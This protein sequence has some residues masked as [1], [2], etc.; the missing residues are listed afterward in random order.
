MSQ[1]IRRES[2]GYCGSTNNVC[3]YL[4]SFGK[5][6]SKCMTPNCAYNAS[7]KVDTVTESTLSNLLTIGEYTD[8]P[9]RGISERVCIEFNYK[10]TVIKGQTWHI[11]HHYDLTGD[12]KAQKIRILPKKF[13]WRGESHNLRLGRGKESIVKDRAY[14]FES[15]LDAMSAA[16]VIQDEAFTFFYLTGGAGKQTVYEITRNMNELLKYN[17]IVVCFDNDLAGN[18]EIKNVSKLF[19]IGK[20]KVIKLKYKDPN[21]YLQKQDSISLIDDL[22]NI[23]PYIPVEIVSPTFEKVFSERPMGRPFPEKMLNNY[24]RGLKAGRLY[25]LLAGP[26][27]GK[28][29]LTRHW[30]L[31]WLKEDDSLKIAVA[32]LEEPV[33]DSALALIAM[34]NNKPYFE[35][36][37]KINE[38]KQN[39]KLIQTYKKYIESGRIKFLDASFMKLDG[40]DLLYNLEYFAELGYSIIILDH[41]S[42]IT[43]DTLGN[44]SERKDI[45]ILMKRLR[46]LAHKTQ[47]SIIVVC[48]LK[49][50]SKGM[51]WDQ[52]REISMSDGRG[53]GVYEQVCDVM[54]AI[55]R[56]QYDDSQK[57]QTK[58]KVLA[59][60]ITGLTGYADVLYYMED[61]GRLCTIEQIFKKDKL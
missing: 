13:C 4:D 29:T 19:P 41:V 14:I 34:D 48:H 25:M 23:S 47:V 45:D 59:N 18:T 54:I 38:F 49:R 8:L 56:N 43:Y 42:M 37:E 2:C 39:D 50:P 24:V 53:S 32:Y 6:I 60:R 31:N 11:E 55:E 7:T 44:Q 22:L 51:S 61:T 52:G 46:Q 15:A 33:E 30:S 57:A 9:D 16:E 40:D 3:F 58:L 17:E 26:K 1:T 10:V 5:E 36:E 27:A 20:V 12:L 35:V 21:E 28:S